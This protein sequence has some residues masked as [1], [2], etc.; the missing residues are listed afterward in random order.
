MIKINEAV[1][2]FNRV[3]HKYGK[4]TVD[5]LI[6]GDLDIPNLP[7]VLENL[8]LTCNI[9]APITFWTKMMS[10]TDFTDCEPFE[11]LSRTDTPIFMTADSGFLTAADFGWDNNQGDGILTFRSMALDSINSRIRTL[12]RLRGDTKEIPGKEAAIKKLTKSIIDDMPCSYLIENTVSVNYRSLNGL[13]RLYKIYKDDCNLPEIREFNEFLEQLPYSI[14]I[15][16]DLSTSL[17]KSIG[18]A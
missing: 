4:D 14:Y 6:Q 7:D 12:K 10:I 5:R 13:Y 18:L 9:K 11:T 1:P 3:E 8:K 15:T 2:Y 17:N 16:A